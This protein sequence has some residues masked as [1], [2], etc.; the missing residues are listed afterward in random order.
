MFYKIIKYNT[1]TVDLT[2]IHKV[3]NNTNG[4]R[5]KY[6]M[7]PVICSLFSSF[8]TQ[9]VAQSSVLAFGDTGLISNN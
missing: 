1:N 5:I 4:M 7:W 2:P 6:F 8:H 3:D 9:G